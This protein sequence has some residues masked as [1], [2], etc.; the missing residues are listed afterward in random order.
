VPSPEGDMIRGAEGVIET[1]AI[2]LQGPATRSCATKTSASSQPLPTTAGSSD[3]SRHGLHR[4]RCCAQAHRDR[5]RR[6]ALAEALS[7][8]TLPPT[9]ACPVLVESPS[10]ALPWPAGSRARRRARRWR[11]MR[12]RHQRRPRADRRPSRFRC[13]RSGTCP[14][15]LGCAL[16]RSCHRG[17]RSRPRPWRS[18]ESCLGVRVETRAAL[19]LHMRAQRSA[20]RWRRSREHRIATPT[21]RPNVRDA[22]LAGMRSGV[23]S[24]GREAAWLS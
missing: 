6:R 23:A 9:I 15:T 18:A 7:L 24:T 4:D 20:A 1:A 11:C 21:Q 12:R 14:T 8:E 5:A 13:L 17:S 10:R 19:L 16:R 2:E 3:R 22:A